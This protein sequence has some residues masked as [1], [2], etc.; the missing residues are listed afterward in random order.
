VELTRPLSQVMVYPGASR[1]CESDFAKFW[2]REARRQTRRTSFFTFLLGRFF[3][4][5]PVRSYFYSLYAYCR[6]VDDFADDFTV[7][8]PERLSFIN[9]QI[10]TV[11][12]AYAGEPRP[13]APGAPEAYLQVLAAW[14][15]A[16]GGHLHRSLEGFLA[17]MKFDVARNGDSPS[18]A[19]LDYYTTLEAASYL[20]A[21]RC[22]CS[23]RSP[24]PPGPIPAE[25]VA[26]KWSHNLR[27][28]SED[29]RDGVINISREDALRFRIEPSH[30]ADPV[31]HPGLQDWLAAKI[32]HLDLMFSQGKQRLL[33]EKCWRYQLSVALLCAKYEYYLKNIKKNHRRFP[34]YRR[35]IPV[36]LTNLLHYFGFLLKIFQGHFLKC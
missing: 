1:P 5:S 18:R 34:H 12:E 11:T 8:Q 16:R 20:W 36:G 25:G 15:K 19:D 23:S 2:L 31:N 3:I 13:P 26:G 21:F 24:A 6:L 32:A 30:L 17:C 27:D 14:D 28:F 4:P 9:R 7:P 33:Q 22:F 10:Q 29:W 35:D